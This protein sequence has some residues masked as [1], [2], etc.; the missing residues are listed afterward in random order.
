MN[1]REIATQEFRQK[2]PG[3]PQYTLDGLLAYWYDKTPVS[4]FLTAVLENN[5]MES[6]ARADEYNNKAIY[7]IC[8][9]VYCEM[10]NDCHGSQ[11]IV[12]R[13]LG[14]I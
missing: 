7:E 2:F 6:F 5:L 12:R 13:W 10:P 11:E 1:E 3:V 4:S 14:S 9:F 8:K